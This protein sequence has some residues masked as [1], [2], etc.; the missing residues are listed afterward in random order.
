[1][2]TLDQPMLMKI[3][4]AAVAA[5]LLIG[6]YLPQVRKAITD[7][8]SS[9]SRPAPAPQPPQVGTVEDMK[10]IL[11]MADRLRKAG[12]TKAVDA[13]QELIDLMLHNEG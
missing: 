1:M 11:E 8:M 2:P 5:W 3:G 13:C 4:A 9:L 10:T 12:N 7:A 6:P